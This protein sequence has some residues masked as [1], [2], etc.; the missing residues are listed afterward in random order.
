MKV[1]RVWVFGMLIL[2]LLAGCD[3]QHGNAVTEVRSVMQA[4][5]A[6]SALSAEKGFAVAFSE[7]A[8]NRALL[9]PENGAPL[10]S[11]ATIEQSL[12]SM[13]ARDTLSWTPQGADASGKL[14]YSWGV[15]ILTGATQ[16]A[17]ATAAYGKYLSVW[18]QRS[19]DWKLAAMMINQSPGPSGD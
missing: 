17:R 11:K 15:Y 2:G 16:G 6:F 3:R 18:K 9:L 5:R 12:K 4:D 8:T 1:L 7:Y 19:G 14:G 10:R 13:P